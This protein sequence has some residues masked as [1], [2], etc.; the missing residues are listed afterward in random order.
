MAKK[1]SKYTR[2]EL[3]EALK[4]RYLKATKKD[5]TRIL[6]EFAAVTGYNRKY[7]VRL[8]GGKTQVRSGKAKPDVAM[9]EKAWAR[10]VWHESD[11]GRDRLFFARKR[12]RNR[13]QAWSRRC[14]GTATAGLVYRDPA[15]LYPF[16]ISCPDL[17]NVKLIRITA[18]HPERVARPPGVSSLFGADVSLTPPALM[19]NPPAGRNRR[20][21]DAENPTAE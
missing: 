1:I 19:A 10:S 2:R 11:W 9:L 3:L 7:A 13:I 12:L 16:L 14:A 5:K 20:L 6:D 8:L 17:S 21:P 18:A 4:Y 15:L